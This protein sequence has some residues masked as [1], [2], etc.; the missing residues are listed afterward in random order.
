[1]LEDSKVDRFL[2]RTDTPRYSMLGFDVDITNQIGLSVKF[3]KHHIILRF[4]IPTLLWISSC[5]MPAMLTELAE[6]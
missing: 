5:S 4:L 6:A 3:N 1:M 2:L